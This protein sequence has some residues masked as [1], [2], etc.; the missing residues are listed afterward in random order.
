MLVVDCRSLYNYGWLT[1]AALTVA[2]VALL[3]GVVAHATGAERSGAVPNAIQSE[4]ALPGMTDWQARSSDHID[5]YTTQLTSAP[6][7]SI[8]FHVSTATRYRIVVYRLGWY[9]GAGARLMACLPSCTDDEQGTLQRQPGAPPALATDPP[10]RANWPITDTLHVG[11]DWTSGYYLAEA[12]I[13]Y[14]ID[15]GRVASA[16]FIVHPNDATTG[17]KILVQVPVNTWEA[18]NSWGGKSLY[19]FTGDRMY[20]VSF[21]RP[22]G[23]LA[24]SP[25]WWEIQL[26]RF[27]EREGYDVS[28]QTDIDTDANP[29]SLLEHRLIVDA[30]HDEYWTS[31][32]RQAFATALADGT[33]LAFMGANEGY[34]RVKYEDNAQTIFTYKSLYDPARSLS[35]KTAMFREI[36]YPECEI[37]GDQFQSLAAIPR[38]LDYTVTPAATTD[39]WFA[40]TGL[41]PGTII[42]GT[43]SREHDK[44]NPYPMSCFHPGLVDLFHYDGH[45]VDSDGDAVRYTAPSGARVFASGSFQFNWALDSWRDDGS[46]VP[47]QQLDGLQ[48]NIVPADPG[49]QQ[50][51]RNALEDLQQPA[52]PTGVTVSQTGGHLIVNVPPSGD[53]RVVNFFAGVKT[54]TGWTRLCTGTTECAGAIPDA[55]TNP[56]TV[57]VVWRD[58]WHTHG[59][60]FFVKLAPRR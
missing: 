55:A 43:V 24:Q 52:E 5:V 14:G 54:A 17:S 6:G 23:Y 27:L 29:N 41:T 33:N 37:E 28:Y 20:R 35:D 11:D 45:G 40:G 32:M 48:P 22:F 15:Y 44:I 56:A 19:D 21:E 13:T 38:N 8:D 26:V 39:P 12:T 4:N 60:A 34:W 7:G 2:G 50:F 25:L 51:M 57:G 42:R 9:G 58:A 49:V 1:K 3:V 16:I 18:Y 47:M 46:L 59:A 30:G 10:I 31:G 36:G 53:P